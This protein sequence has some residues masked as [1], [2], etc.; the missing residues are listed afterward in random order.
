[1]WVFVWMCILACMNLCQSLIRGIS[2]VTTFSWDSM[3]V[4]L[5]LCVCSAL[6][7]TGYLW[8][9]NDFSWWAKFR[10]LIIYTVHRDSHTLRPML[11]LPLPTFLHCFSYINTF[12]LHT[13]I[14]DSECLGIGCTELWVHSSKMISHVLPAALAALSF[15]MRSGLFFFLFLITLVVYL[16][17]NLWVLHFS[18]VWDFLLSITFFVCQQTKQLE[19]KRPHFSN[20][21]CKH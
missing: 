21:C 11:T 14:A 16:S 7:V 10:Q 4:C 9:D 13:F 3:R 15:G 6:L 18:R 8:D 17:E 19:L 12:F 20:I 1:M 2:Q 5:Y